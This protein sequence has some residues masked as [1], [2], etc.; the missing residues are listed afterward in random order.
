MNA[1]GST[2]DQAADAIAA[3][4]SLAL[5]CHHTPDGDALGSLLALHHLALANGKESVA[6]WPEPFPVPPHTE[7]LPGLRLAT[8]PSDFPSEPE[9]M[10]TFDCGSIGRLAELGDAARRA[11]QL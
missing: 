3:A 4:P 8:K 9:L 2:L 1:F 7:F 6:S 10:V 5:A 11:Q